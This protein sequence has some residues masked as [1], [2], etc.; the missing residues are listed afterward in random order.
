LTIE[1][2]KAVKC[3]SAAYHLAG[4]KKVQQELALPGVLEKYGLP[5]FDSR[6]ESFDPS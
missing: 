2:S 5:L 3:P 4:L 1:K 6:I